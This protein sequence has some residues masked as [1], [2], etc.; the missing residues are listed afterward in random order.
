[1]TFPDYG[2]DVTWVNEHTGDTKSGTVWRLSV[3]SPHVPPYFIAK[4]S[5]GADIW[6]EVQTLVTINGEPV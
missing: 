3:D 6:G 2:D 1:M 5:K 4:D